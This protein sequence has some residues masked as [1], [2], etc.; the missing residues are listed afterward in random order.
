M[1]KRTRDVRRNEFSRLKS[2]ILFID[3]IFKEEKKKKRKKTYSGI[4]LFKIINGNNFVRSKKAIESN[5]MAQFNCVCYI[6][7]TL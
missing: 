3:L 5:I 6:H 1:Q 2:E 4:I 7:L